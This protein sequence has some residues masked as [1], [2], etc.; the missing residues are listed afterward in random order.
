MFSI[1]QEKDTEWV[2]S[3]PIWVDR[4]DSHA[5]HSGASAIGLIP[6][7]TFFFFNGELLLLLFDAGC[8]FL[9]T[10]GNDGKD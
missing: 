8:A 2:D 4:K 10:T 6:N 1:L 5:H 9:A 3:L 7:T